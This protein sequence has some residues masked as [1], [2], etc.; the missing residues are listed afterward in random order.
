MSNWCNFLGTLSGY[1]QL[2][3]KCSQNLSGCHIRSWELEKALIEAEETI[4]QLELLTPRPVPPKI[5]NIGEVDSSWIDAKLAPL[6]VIR[7][8]LD[9][10]YRLTDKTNFLNIVAWDW[11]DSIAYQ[12]DIYDCENFAIS[13]KAHV[14][15][16]FGLNQ[17]GIVID[18]QAGHAYNLVIF[19]DG[20]VML[21]EPQSDQLFFWEEDMVYILKDAFVLI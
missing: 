2:Y 19:P 15:Y 14:D 12:K 18:Y 11:V 17:V 7:F 16:Y 5:T 3:E 10:K 8:P 13:F 21:F 1:K 4:R 6:E 9:G 20:K